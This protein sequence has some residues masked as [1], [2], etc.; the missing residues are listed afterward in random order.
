MGLIKSIGKPV[1]RYHYKLAYE[2]SLAAALIIGIVGFKY[3]PVIDTKEMKYDAPQELFKLEDIAQTKQ[4]NEPPPP[5][6]PKILIAAP[7][8]EE[9]E[10]I[11]IQSTELRVNEEVAP[12]PP[13]PKIKETQQTEPEPQYFVAVEE[14][15]SIIGG[16]ASI[17]EKIVYP[18]IALRAGIEGKVY[19]LAFVDENGDVTKTKVIKGI[20]GGCDEAAVKAVRQA[21]FIPGKQRGKPVRVQ[22]MV[23]V[24][25]KLTRAPV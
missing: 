17:Q 20:G 24:I 13:P 14:M 12:P 7:T 19:V 5:P 18:P 21:K 3:F 1:I 2:I 25:F 15:P 11:E 8:T 4:I 9:L 6:E 23:P 22:V 10:D 16:V